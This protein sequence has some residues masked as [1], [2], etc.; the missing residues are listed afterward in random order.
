MEL[1]LKAPAVSLIETH[2]NLAYANFLILAVCS[3]CFLG[4]RESADVTLVIPTLSTR[5]TPHRSQ[6]PDLR[7][8]GS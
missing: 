8:H 3:N 2:L 6:R 5:T 7:A 4:A 1:L